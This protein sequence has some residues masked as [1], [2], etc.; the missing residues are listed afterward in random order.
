M[1]DN[2]HT[3]RGWNGKGYYIA[4]ILCAAAIGITSYVYSRNAETAEEVLLQESEVI[5]VG[6][7]TAVEDIPVIA[8]HPQPESTG[9]VPPSLEP[10]MPNFK[11]R[12][13]ISLPWRGRRS[14][15]IPWRP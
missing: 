10:T 2:K 8:T 4:L 5:P 12:G 3:G 14:T 15:A 6:T 1:S 11:P 7:M 13:I 9:T